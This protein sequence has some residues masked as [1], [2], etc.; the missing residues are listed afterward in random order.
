MASELF[1]Y[2]AGPSPSTIFETPGRRAAA[3]YKRELIE[4]R[5][6]ASR[7]REALAREEAL[8]R[9]KDELIRQQEVLS[10][11]CDHRLMNGLQMIASLLSLQGRAS[12]NAEVASQLA[13]AASRVG[14]I[15]RVHRRLHYFDGVQIIEFK[16]Y[17]EEFCRDFS[18]M[19]SS[20]ERPERVIVVEGIEITL[21]TVIG[22]PL[23]FIANELITNAVEYGEGQITSGWK[24][25]P[26]R[27]TRCRSPMMAQGCRK[28]LI[29]PRAKD[30]E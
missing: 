23:G 10:R 18:A 13:I 20:E 7:L 27:A 21:L 24:R 1:L 8:L 12:G 28:D 2:D 3:R 4:H 16:Q 25:I 29:Q 9:Q 6:M 11:E 5:H 19:V 26:E 14:M 17:L 15:E 22:I 30:W